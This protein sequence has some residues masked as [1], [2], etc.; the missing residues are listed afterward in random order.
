MKKQ[1][2]ANREGGGTLFGNERGSAL[3]MTLGVLLLM[4]VIGLGFMYSAMTERQVA[5]NQAEAAKARNLAESGMQR[6]LAILNRNLAAPGSA[7]AT[8]TAFSPLAISLFDSSG[9]YTFPAG[10]DFAPAMIDTRQ[11]GCVK[12][13]II[14]RTGKIDPNWWGRPSKCFRVP[15]AGPN[16][17]VGDADDNPA[18]WDLIDWN[19]WPV[20]WSP[21]GMEMVPPF[22][23]TETPAQYLAKN[24]RLFVADPVLRNILRRGGTP[25]NGNITDFTDPTKEDPMKWFSRDQSLAEIKKAVPDANFTQNGDPTAADF[26]RDILYPYSPMPVVY[27]SGSG[28]SFSLVPDPATGG[29]NTFIDWGADWRDLSKVTPSKI[30]LRV[31]VEYLAALDFSAANGVNDIRFASTVPY[32][33]ASATPANRE[34]GVHLPWFRAL[35]AQRA[36]DMSSYYELIANIKDYLSSTAEPTN[37]LW[38]VGVAFSDPTALS[39]ATGVTTAYPYCGNK[40][41]P[42]ISEVRLN[43]SRNGGVKTVQVEVVN[44]YPEQYSTALTNLAAVV[45]VEFTDGKAPSPVKTYIQKFV[46]GFGSGSAGA[47]LLPS[48]TV[49][50]PTVYEQFVAT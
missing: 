26:N 5:A 46:V 19:L 39:N 34:L 17:V 37:N 24:D 6:G 43:F 31:P 36:A 45:E 15:S 9:Y 14:N 41:T 8:Y 48:L 21:V 40:A 22:G 11:I 23:G 10:E 32:F 3:L 33:G 18:K 27:A 28:G 35:K 13:E 47:Q 12:V 30:R 16:K 7:A 20:G 38:P 42:S 44:L 1:L 4:L 25:V 50:D 2:L 49:S 29:S